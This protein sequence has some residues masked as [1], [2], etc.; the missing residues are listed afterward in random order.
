VR[1]RLSVAVA[2]ALA[3]ASAHA[4]QG[5]D[6]FSESI[7]E[8]TVNGEH[9]ASPLVVRRDAD[10]TLLVRA[11]DLQALRIRT[12]PRGAITV[13]GQLYFRIGSE[14]G[15]NVSFDDATQSV[16]VNLPAQAFVPTAARYAS[17]DAP[18]AADTQP[19]AF[20]NYDISAQHTAGE[21][22]AGSFV[23]AGV[24]GSRGV[25]TAS[26]VARTG[27]YQPGGVR[28]DTAWT[29]DFADRMETLRIGDSISS[30]GSWGRS[31]RFA[32][33]QYG[34]N[35]STRP[36]FVT[37]PLLSASGDAVLPSTVEVFVN[38]NPVAS[39]TV[40]PG[41][42][43]I[44]GVPA[45]NGAGQMQV[46][47]TDALG[48]EQVVSQPYYAGAALL[49]E[50][51]TE[52]S[53]E[54]GAIRQDYA[55]KSNNY[56][57]A[58]GAATWRRGITDRFTAEVHG[59]AQA[60]GAAAGGASGAVQVGTL[61]IVSANAAVG[62]SGNG[63]GW[64][65]GFGFES[66]RR[67]VSVYARTLYASESFAQLGDGFSAVRPRSRIFGG[68][69]FNLSGFGS[70]QFAYGRQS[71][72]GAPGAQTFGLGYTLGLGYLG[73]LNLFA[74]Y[75]DSN[76]STTDV[77]L[78]W[79]L[80]FGER[81]TASATL[82]QS[83]GGD[84]PQDGFSAVGTVQQ[85]LPVGSGSGYIASLSSADD[86]HLGYAY[87]GHAGLVTADWASANGQDGL[88]VGG[89]GGIAITDAG[90]MASRRLD[91]SFAM[92]KV[93]DYEGIQVYVDN[94]PVGR[95]DRQGRV[96]LDRLLPYQTNEVSI[97]PT[98]LP[99]DATI[100]SPSM[101]VTPAY[102]SGLSV[103][104]PVSRADSVTLRLVQL[105]GQPVPAG[106]QVMFEGNEFPVANDG[107]VYLSGVS[108]NVH[109]SVT[110]RDGRCSADFTRPAGGGPI[111]DLG[112]V[113]CR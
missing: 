60:D 102:R 56:G 89:V 71:N 19:G 41:P 28:L 5:P 94:Q 52:Y 92:V 26:A 40:Q 73:T 30:S 36:T 107:L 53:V 61:G 79:T 75:S 78:T 66:S 64:L 6:A 29:R 57:N 98:E 45:V 90:V 65:G 32:G 88:R 12:P 62:G 9:L 27:P 21:M 80:S 10:G 111:P 104:F 59:E 95:T 68:L 50:G 51:L 81:G 72:W 24:F 8:V 55:T 108:T 35:F 18:H 67:S 96:L 11:E 1:F 13:N 46:V 113:T 42:F 76:E 109:A 70:L 7:L 97:D 2:L 22:S 23:E 85:S 82:Q 58:V 14:I 112:D 38:G 20:V 48:R 47:V 99:M 63:L 105:D 87:Q 17:A 25:V 3:G 103:R 83:S 106:A 91:Q 93:A 84:G 43:Q 54:A 34:T 100:S 49:R 74:N 15:A 4:R 86:Y 16:D 31:A 110:W 33:V 77:F 39:E 69:G 44:E 37:T 101:T